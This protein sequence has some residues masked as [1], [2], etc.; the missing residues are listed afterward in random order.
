MRHSRPSHVPGKPGTYKQ[1]AQPP[2]VDAGFIPHVAFPG[3]PRA[4]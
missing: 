2:I 4:G 1:I 3:K